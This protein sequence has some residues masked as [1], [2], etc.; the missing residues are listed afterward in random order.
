MTQRKRVGSAYA[1]LESVM[2]MAGIYCL[3][4]P[5]LEAVEVLPMRLLRRGFTALAPSV[6]LLG[7]IRV[8]SHSFSAIAGHSTVRCTP[9]PSSLCTLFLSAP[10]PFKLRPLPITSYSIAYPRAHCSASLLSSP[11]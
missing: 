9:Y 7:A 10:L 5:G 8:A 4:R 3:D 2:S 6:S 1:I 11:I